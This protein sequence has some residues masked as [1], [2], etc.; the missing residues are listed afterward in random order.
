LVSVPQPFDNYVITLF[1]GTVKGWVLI[2][3]VFFLWR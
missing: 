1:V 2:I 3:F